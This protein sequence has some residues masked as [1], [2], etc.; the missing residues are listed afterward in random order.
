MP[1]QLDGRHITPFARHPHQMN[2]LPP[3]SC[4]SRSP[5]TAHGT[6]PQART[7]GLTSLEVLSLT[8]SPMAARHERKQQLVLV[9]SATRRAP[10]RARSDQAALLWP[11]GARSLE[12]WPIWAFGVCHGRRR[13][14]VRHRRALSTPLTRA[15][16]R[17]P[18]PVSALQQPSPARRV[19]RCRADWWWSGGGRR[20]S[21]PRQRRLWPPPRP[22]W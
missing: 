2:E 9:R 18:R 3:W 20:V 5:G 7:H 14:G 11:L 16:H 13:P 17:L 19:R 10:H 6:R 22:L 12:S 4:A 15:V 8:C 1:V 21:S